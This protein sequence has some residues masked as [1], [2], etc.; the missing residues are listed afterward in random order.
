MSKAGIN[1]DVL[2]RTIQ[3]TRSSL[4]LTAQDVESLKR[5]GVSDRVVVAMLD[6]NQAVPASAKPSEPPVSAAR[7]TSGS[8][9]VSRPSGPQVVQA[10]PAAAPVYYTGPVYYNTAPTYYNTTPPP[11]IY[12]PD[13]GA[14]DYPVRY[15]GFSVISGR[16]GPPGWNRPGPP[17][18]GGRADPGW[19]Q[20]GGWNRSVLS[21]GP[22]NHNVLSHAPLSYSVLPRGSGGRRG[23]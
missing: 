12:Y 13:Y 18:L 15:Y 14:Y 7:E 8:D 1:D 16:R 2:I 11:T 17:S 5:D 10:V 21:H 6:T 22:A 4:H 20:R 23:R 19:P 9:H 3:S